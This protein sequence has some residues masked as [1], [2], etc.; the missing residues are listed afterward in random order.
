M[1]DDCAWSV[2]G[3]IAKDIASKENKYSEKFFLPSLID[4][5]PIK[6]QYYAITWLLSAVLIYLFLRD[7]KI[8]KEIGL[9]KDEVNRKW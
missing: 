9:D 7:S 3:E 1:F 2:I 6:I 8:V 5:G 4:I